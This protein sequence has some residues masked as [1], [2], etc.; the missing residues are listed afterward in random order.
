ML[1]SFQ[2]LCANSPKLLRTNQHN[3]MYLRQQKQ[4]SLITA[5]NRFGVLDVGRKVLGTVGFSQNEQ[6]QLKLNTSYLATDTKLRVE[7]KTTKRSRG[8]TNSKISIHRTDVRNEASWQQ[9]ECKMFAFSALH[10]FD[11][12]TSIAIQFSI[13]PC[14]QQ[15]AQVKAASRQ[16]LC[17]NTN[18]S[19]WFV[20][21]HLIQN[22]NNFDKTEIK[23]SDE[24]PP[25]GPVEL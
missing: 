20:S 24:Q 5:R 6:R 14:Y 21:R 9:N 13:V 12:P 3:T 11:P 22:W 18:E 2:V 4:N 8:E 23:H 16:S 1:C 10:F 7:H 25:Q 19:C 17:R 15:R